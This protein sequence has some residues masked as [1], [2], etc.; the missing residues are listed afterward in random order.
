MKLLHI[1]CYLVFAVFILAMSA[2]KPEKVFAAQVC[3]TQRY[4]KQFAC[5]TN[6]TGRL[7]C[8]GPGY[9]G[10]SGNPSRPCVEGSSCPINGTYPTND[11][12]CAWYCDK[13][14]TC[15]D[16]GCKCIDTGDFLGKCSSKADRCNWIGKLQT[17]K[18]QSSG[19]CVD[20]TEV[21]TYGCWSGTGLCPNGTCDIGETCSNC[22]ADCTICLPTPTPTPIPTPP[23]PVCENW[24][25]IYINGCSQA[26]Y[27][28]TPRDPD[29]FTNTRTVTLHLDSSNATQMSFV[30]VGIYDVCADAAYIYGPY[31][32]AASKSWTLTTGYGRK[33]V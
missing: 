19:T 3:W 7:C 13:W 29:C 14:L 18:T 15:T 30:N 11:G 12:T 32:Y 22:P 28:T 24:A 20:G 5:E 16:V 6:C 8:D 10:C 21:L 17:C 25:S 33:K 23:L 9:W 2:L 1:T 26:E 4:M 31:T 27:N